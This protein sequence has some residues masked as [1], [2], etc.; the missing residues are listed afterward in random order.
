MRA[1]HA[2]AIL[3][4]LLSGPSIAAGPLSLTISQSS[5]RINGVE[6]RSRPQGTSGHYISLAAAEKVLGKPQDTYVAGLGVRVY[7]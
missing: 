7:A 3:S 1:T 5:I 2:A 4:A 6:L